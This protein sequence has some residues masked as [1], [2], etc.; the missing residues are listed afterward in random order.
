MASDGLFCQKLNEV[1]IGG[2]EPKSEKLKLCAYAYFSCFFFWI[3][4]VWNKQ[5]NNAKNNIFN[6][7]VSQSWKPF[8]FLNNGM[9]DGIS[10][11]FWE[12]FSQVP[13]EMVLNLQ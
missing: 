9:P 4:K 10:S 8:S 3:V 13:W 12:Y 1:Q 11:D 6:I 7:S 5:S 2:L